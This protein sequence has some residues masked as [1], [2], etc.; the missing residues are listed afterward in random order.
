MSEVTATEA[1]RSFSDL[2]DAVEHRGERFTIV[3]RGKAVAQLQPLAE[4]H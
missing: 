2:L 1:A 4:G 3:R